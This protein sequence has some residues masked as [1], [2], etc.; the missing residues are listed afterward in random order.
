MWSY[1]KCVGR[2]LIIG[3]YLACCV[4]HSP[5]RL[6]AHGD[7]H[8]R[9]LTLSARIQAS[10]GNAELLLQRAD[11]HRVHQ[12]WALALADYQRARELC[13]TEDLAL[14]GMGRTWFECGEPVEA[15]PLLDAFL[16]QHPCHPEALI[17]RARTLVALGQGRAAVF[18]YSSAL[19]NSSNQL[20][21]T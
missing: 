1:H 15:R 14:L 3:L 5:E 18:D 6:W 7:L 4:P 13:P 17:V 9:I 21:A 16:K 11:L 12:E 2:F 10:P 19:E 8:E 20:P